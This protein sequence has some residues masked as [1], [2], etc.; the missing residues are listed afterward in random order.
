M[1][2]QTYTFASVNW[3]TVDLSRQEKRKL[4]NILDVGGGGGQFKSIKDDW[5]ML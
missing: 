5:I 2:F 3:E 1:L 4:T